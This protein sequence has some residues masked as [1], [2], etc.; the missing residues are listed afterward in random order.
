M[1]VHQTTM[2]TCAEEKNGADFALDAVFTLDGTLIIGVLKKMV[3]ND[4]IEK[5]QIQRNFS[6][7]IKVILNL[8]LPYHRNDRFRI[9]GFGLCNLLISLY[10]K[11]I[12]PPI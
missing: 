9:R 11:L 7:N 6:N 10:A 3:Q 5:Y 1:R 12:E 4:N 2:I 8:F